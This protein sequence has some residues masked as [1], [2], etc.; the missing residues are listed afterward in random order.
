MIPLELELHNFLAYRVPGPLSFEGMHV[1]CLAGPNGAGKSSILDAI[2]WSLWGRARS[3][4]PDELIHQG[5]TE[6]RVG[7]TFQQGPLRYRVVRQ[8]KS[9]K[10]GQSLLELQVWD[11]FTGAWRGLS[12]T[13]MR[14]TQ[15]KIDAL[16]HLDFDTFVNSA[17]LMQGRAD[18]FTKKA[19]AQRKQVLAAILGLERWEVY[20]DRAKDRLSR[21]RADIQR[22]DGRLEEIE[23]EL[24]Q[25]NAYQM[26]LVTA[27][28]AASGTAQAL[29][30]AEQQWAGLERSRNQLVALQ[31]Q[32]DDLTRRIGQRRRAG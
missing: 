31:R 27:E 14:S 15:D 4:S 6:M 20:E 30:D 3:G 22:L 17:F 8:R 32:I 9:G 13:N 5:Q 19:P 16:L 12:E 29:A 18:E 24:G 26:E 21:T 11:E 7:L 2:T 23:R 1:A 25:R 10:R 28:A